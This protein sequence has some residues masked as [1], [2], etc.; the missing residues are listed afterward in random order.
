MF[1]LVALG[2]IL[3]PAPDFMHWFVGFFLLCVLFVF[4]IWDQLYLYLNI[5]FTTE[6]FMSVNFDCVKGKNH[7]YFFDSFL[8][9]S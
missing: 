5:I 6:Y 1:F 8:S 4:L 3:L 7:I 2:E 9:Q